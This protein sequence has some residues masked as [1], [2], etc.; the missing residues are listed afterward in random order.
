MPY[1]LDHYDQR[2]ALP[3]TKTCTFFALKSA[4]IASNLG[5]YALV[6]ML[7]TKFDQ[8]FVSPKKKIIFRCEIITTF[9]INLKCAQ[10]KCLST[11]LQKKMMQIRWQKGAC[12]KMHK[13]LVGANGSYA[14][15]LFW[16]F[17]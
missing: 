1:M 13:Y 15:T 4:N 14:P 12:T 17:P 16:I 3:K 10:K 7:L 5:F 2:R 6:L 11:T 8:I 9:N